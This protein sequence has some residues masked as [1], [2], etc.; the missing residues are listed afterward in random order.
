M[1]FKIDKLDE[2]TSNDF[3]E[4]T[5]T[6]MVEVMSKQNELV[7]KKILEYCREHNI[8]PLIIEEEKLRTVLELGIQE[9]NRRKRINDSVIMTDF[10]RV[11]KVIEDMWGTVETGISP[12]DAI[13]DIFIWDD[14]D[15]QVLLCNL[16]DEFDID[17]DN[18]ERFQYMPIGEIAQRLGEMKGEI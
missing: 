14:L 12:T 16:E 18:I 6:F 10:E 8:V 15:M 3:Y 1:E 7:Y 13:D 4:I 2:N 9:Y 17:I 11:V 5:Q